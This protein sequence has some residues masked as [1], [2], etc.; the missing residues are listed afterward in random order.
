M[1]ADEIGIAIP[2]RMFRPKP[3]S[4]HKEAPGA[5]CQFRIVTMK[6]TTQTSNTGDCA[7]IPCMNALKMLEFMV[8]GN[9]PLGLYA[10]FRILALAINPPALN[11]SK[12]KR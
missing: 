4:D 8:F 7:K 1:I 12:T 6:H 3:M 11:K 10:C 9:G 2:R 5:C